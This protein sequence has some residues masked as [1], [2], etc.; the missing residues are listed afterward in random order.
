R[1][2]HLIGM[3]P[4][5]DCQTT[6][7]AGSAARGTKSRVGKLI[8]CS[9][10]ELIPA[11]VV[12]RALPNR[13]DTPRTACVV[14]HDQR[15]VASVAAVVRKDEV[16]FVAKFPGAVDRR[17]SQRRAGGGG[18][19]NS[20]VDESVENRRFQT[21]LFWIVNMLPGA[22]AARPMLARR[23]RTEMRTRGGDAVRR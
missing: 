14:A 10:C 7:R 1:R 8:S 16:Y 5:A 19:R 23:S 3:T 12:D 2:H 17:G 6:D 21:E 22:A 4:D 11:L 20:L 18:V 15:A 13:N 9:E